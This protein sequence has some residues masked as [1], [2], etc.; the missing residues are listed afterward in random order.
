MTEKYGQIK[1]G[2]V[3]SLTIIDLDKEVIIT[4]E[5]LKTKP[6]WSPFLGMTFHGSVVMTVVKGKTYAK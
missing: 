2:Y 1:E 6:K 4:E 5:K 3:G